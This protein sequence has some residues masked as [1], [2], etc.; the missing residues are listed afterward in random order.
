MIFWTQNL[1]AAQKTRKMLFSL[2]PQKCLP[3]L[4]IFFVIRIIF[5]FTFFPFH[6]FFYSQEKQFSV[7]IKP[8]KEKENADPKKS[9]NLVSWR[10]IFLGLTRAFV[11][12]RKARGWICSFYYRNVGYCATWWTYLYIEFVKFRHWTTMELILL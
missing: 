12:C 11:R 1:I 9:S 2:I 7:H 10:Q 6:I 4:T 3:Y 8:K 5:L